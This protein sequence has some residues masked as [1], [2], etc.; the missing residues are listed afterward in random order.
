[1]AFA[2]FSFPQVQQELGLALHEADLYSAVP[3]VPLRDEFVATVTDGATVALAINTEKAKSE[4]IVAPV[5]LELRRLLGG[6]VGLF[7]GI[8]LNVDP[9]RG[10]NG[11]CDFILTKAARQFVLSAPLVT[12]V[13][14]KNDNLRS[15][16]GQ[17]I[18]T[19]YA[20]QLYNQ[21]SGRPV[22]AVS[23]VVTTGSAWKFLRLEGATVTL[24]LREYYI[25]NLGKIL[26]VLKQIIQGA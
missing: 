5:L 24:D 25:D 23:G 13:E 11:V 22:G 17:C 19:M 3:A 20:A 26:G 8:E 10:L 12:V 4:F 6:A 21:Q 2:D 7:S 16:L 1:M 18:A 15:G 14:A 9:S